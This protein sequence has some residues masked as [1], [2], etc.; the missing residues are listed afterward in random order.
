MVGQLP[1]R[2]RSGSPSRRESQKQRS[3]QPQ[4]LPQEPSQQS[5]SQNLS[6]EKTRPEIKELTELE[7]TIA[8]GLKAFY[9]VG[10]ALLQIRDSKLYKLAGYTQFEAYCQEKWGMKRAHAYRVIDSAKCVNNLM[11]PIGRQNTESKM[12]PIGRQ[13]TES[14]MSPI[15]RQ[16]TE[17]KMSPIGRQNDESK[18]SPIGRQNTESKMS[19]IGRQ[20]DES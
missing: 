20:Y 14:K 2:Q 17:S 13:N 15:G 4:N 16:N 6:T 11:S 10:M 8:D 7:A 9:E 18:M 1:P 12:S 19:P 5:S 3:L